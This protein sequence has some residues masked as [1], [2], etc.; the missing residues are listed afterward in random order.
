MRI[1]LPIAT[2]ALVHGLCYGAAAE[3]V[4]ACQW[5]FATAEARFRMPGPR[6]GI[7]LGTQRLAN[8]IG[9]DAARQCV[10]RDA[11]FGAPEAH[12]LGYINGIH[13]TA[14]WPETTKKVLSQVTP[15]DAETYAKLS[16]RQRTDTCNAD[17]AALI[18]SVTRGSVKARVH[19]YLDQM[20]AERK[21]RA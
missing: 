19:A 14:D 15:L 6:F 4:A 3:L 8:L 13:E 12:S 20:A 10:L 7:V 16:A 18:H 5:R 21:A 11:P 2:L 17:L 9:E 1:L